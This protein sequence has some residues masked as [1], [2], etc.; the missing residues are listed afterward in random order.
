MMRGEK[1]MVAIS[2]EEHRLTRSLGSF[3]H[4]IWSTDQWSPRHFVLAARIEG[5]SISVD[6]LRS[7]FLAAQRR[8]PVLRAAISVGSDGC[9]RFVPAASLIP[10][11]VIERLSDTQWQREV[12]GQLVLP[13]DAAT[14]PLL[15]STL[16]RGESIAEL[17]LAAH[18]SIG[19]GISAIYLV[20]DLLESLE[21]NRLEALPPRASLEELAGGQMQEPVGHPPGAGVP[22]RLQ[23]PGT[24]RVASIDIESHELEEFLRRCREK[25][26]TLQ[27]ALL[28]AVLL[29][30]CGDSMARCLAPV[31][32]RQFCPPVGED[33]GLYISAGTA[34]LD[35]DATP[36]FWSVARTASDQVARALDPQLLSARATALAALIAR[37]PDP[38]SS[39]EAYRRGVNYG[40]VLS[41]LGR[42]PTMP[43]VRRFRITAVYPVLNVELEP[44]VGVATANGLMSITITSDS[45]A[46][47]DWLSSVVDLLKSEAA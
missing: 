26:T 32:V 47:A 35:R 14:G 12:E 3:E 11:R 19:D 37:N 27:G 18:H 34:T 38:Q 20:R 6:G 43:A 33:F 10:V 29:S 16:V 31:N 28:A 2:P 44:V 7:A 46:S 13:F 5:G 9:P 8:H 21:G 22:V 36:D 23:R 39:Y 24:P 45:P 15:R 42:L 4:L 30:L 41:N 17:V 40:A 1:V 25:R